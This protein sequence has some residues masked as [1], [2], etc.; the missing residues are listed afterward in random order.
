MPPSFFVMMTAAASA[1]SQ[2]LSG[3]LFRPSIPPIMFQASSLYAIF[4]LAFILLFS[5]LMRIPHVCPQLKKSFLSMIK[6]KG[7]VVKWKSAVNA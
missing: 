4:S 1:S 2:S 3:T 7:K 5:S 6:E